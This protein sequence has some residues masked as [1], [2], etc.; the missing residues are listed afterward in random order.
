VWSRGHRVVWQQRMFIACDGA[1]RRNSTL[2][3]DAVEK[4]E[5]SHSELLDNIIELKCLKAKSKTE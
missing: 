1:T 2:T 4:D 3:D 5:G